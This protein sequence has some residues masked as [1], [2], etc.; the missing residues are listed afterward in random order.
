MLQFNVYS[1][2]NFIFRLIVKFFCGRRTTKMS[3]TVMLYIINPIFK[4]QYFS[5]SYKR[6]YWSIKWFNK[7]NKKI[8]YIGLKTLI[9]LQLIDWMALIFTV[10][11]SIINNNTKV[12]MIY[13]FIVANYLTRLSTFR[14]SWWWFLWISGTLLPK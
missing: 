13:H 7:T 14:S 5:K 11:Y 9:H 10:G 8:I 6:T 4:L 1:Q 3:W 2:K 12:S